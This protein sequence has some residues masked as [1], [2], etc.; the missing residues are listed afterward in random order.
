M[1]RAQGRDDREGKDR[2]GDREP[3][4]GRVGGVVEPPAAVVIEKISRGQ[5][6][7]SLIADVRQRLA[8]KKRLA[9]KRVPGML[10][11]ISTGNLRGQAPGSAKPVSANSN[12]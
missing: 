7:G 5:N 10:G 3:G 9:A 6:S 2:V 12:G 11:H 4:V 1:S 8:S